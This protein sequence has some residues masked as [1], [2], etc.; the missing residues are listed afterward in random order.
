MVMEKKDGMEMGR[1]HDET[2]ART[3]VGEA[4]PWRK[5]MG[6]KQGCMPIGC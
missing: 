2:A 1:R 6:R 3:F 4:W 5:W